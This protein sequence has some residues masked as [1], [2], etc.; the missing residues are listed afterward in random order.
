MVL[1][2]RYFY[3]SSRRCLR[4]MSCSL[5]GLLP[6]VGLRFL[7]LSFSTECFLSSDVVASIE[8]VRTLKFLGSSAHAFRQI[9]RGAHSGCHLFL[10]LLAGMSVWYSGSLFGLRRGDV[11]NRID[12]KIWSHVQWGEGFDGSL[13]FLDDSGVFSIWVDSL[14][15]D[16]N[17]FVQLHFGNEGF[18]VGLICNVA[19]FA[20]DF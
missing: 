15:L 11:E 5:F 9:I 1:L 16:R 7:S 18:I 20:F 4:V 10:T 19:N 2:L 8:N 13:V 6:R 12:P 17:I 3:N 14:D